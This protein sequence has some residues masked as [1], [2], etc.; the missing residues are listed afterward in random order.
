MFWFIAGCVFIGE[1][2]G[3]SGADDVGIYRLDTCDGEPQDETIPI[4][5][6]SDP[7]GPQLWTSFTAPEAGTYILMTQD[8]DTVL[9]VFDADGLEIACND[10]YTDAPNYGSRVEIYLKAG[11]TADILVTSYVNCGP[12]RLDISPEP[13]EDCPDDYSPN[14]SL[15][16]LAALPPRG[17]VQLT[18]GADEDWFDARVPPGHL[19]Y[20]IASDGTFMRTQEYD[21][22]PAVQDS[23]FVNA[24]SFSTAPYGFHLIAERRDRPTCEAYTIETDCFDC[25]ELDDYEPNDTANQ[26]AVVTAGQYPLS[27][28]AFELLEPEENWVPR[29]GSPDFFSVQVVAGQ[30]LTLNPILLGGEL[31]FAAIHPPEGPAITDSNATDG[32]VLSTTAV[33]TGAHIVE[34]HGLECTFYTLDIGVQ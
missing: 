6:A 33:T 20:Y 2:T 25:L 12:F 29:E 11:Q 4:G 15:D 19:C 22:R 34:V 7:Q 26:A 16:E 1:R 14:G 30:T 9:Q 8:N 31:T 28:E 5:C 3:R 10:D 27:F 17:V 18:H 23:T 32:L 13:D 24:W 21:G